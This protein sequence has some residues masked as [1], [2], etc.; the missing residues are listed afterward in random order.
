MTKAIGYEIEDSM[1]LGRFI[2]LLNKIQEDNK[3]AKLN[4]VLRQT[5]GT[6]FPPMIVV[7]NDEYAY[8]SE[9]EGFVRIN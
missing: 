8:E 2:S 1:E 4:V 9:M 3:G 5:D 7:E 6:D